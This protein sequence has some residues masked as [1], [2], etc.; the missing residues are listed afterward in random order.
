ML[1]LQRILPRCLKYYLNSSKQKDKK[2]KTE[3]RLYFERK[4]IEIINREKEEK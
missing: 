1:K 2:Q 3:L 4:R